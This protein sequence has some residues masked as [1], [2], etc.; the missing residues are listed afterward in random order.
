MSYDKM[1]TK[2]G[3]FEDSFSYDDKMIVFIDEN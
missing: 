2:F 3:A 1:V